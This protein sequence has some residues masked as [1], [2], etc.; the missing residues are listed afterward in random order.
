[1]AGWVRNHNVSETKRTFTSDVGCFVF[2]KGQSISVSYHSSACRE[3]VTLDEISY[4]SGE[5]L[6]C[7]F[8]EVDLCSEFE[9]SKQIMLLID[10]RPA[11]T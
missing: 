7:Y 5:A 9:M 3:P 10:G 2:P 11:E 1:M 6:L 4:C 8:K